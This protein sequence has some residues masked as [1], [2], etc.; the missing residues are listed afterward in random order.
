MI[1]IQAVP[2]KTT[3]ATLLQDNEALRRR[4]HELCAKLD[5]NA[6]VIR[7]NNFDIFELK[8]EVEKCHRQRNQDVLLLQNLQEQVEMHKNASLRKSADLVAL[9][10]DIAELH[11]AIYAARNPLKFLSLRELLGFKR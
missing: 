3:K 11:D 10:R 6:E 2:N 8:Q 7:Q 4:V 9:E 5:E 1:E